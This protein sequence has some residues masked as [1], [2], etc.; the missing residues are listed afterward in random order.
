MNEAEENR[1]YQNLGRQ[2][3]A[4]N[5][6]PELNLPIICR[7]CGP[8]WSMAP[9]AFISDGCFWCGNRLSGRAIPRP[10]ITPEIQKAMRE[11]GHAG[12]EAEPKAKKFS[13]FVGSKYL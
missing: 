6:P 12:Q 10:P 1:F 4:G 13:G 5:K 7:E 3:R 8:V 9:A 11:I 2:I